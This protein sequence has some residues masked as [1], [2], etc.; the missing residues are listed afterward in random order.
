MHWSMKL[1]LVLALIVLFVQLA[2][3]T[4]VPVKHG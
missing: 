4:L 1:L 3:Q 2:S